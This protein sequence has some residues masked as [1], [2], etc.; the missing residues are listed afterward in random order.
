[1]TR[2]RQPDDYD[3]VLGALPSRA[4]RHGSA[5]TIAWALVAGLIALVV[6]TPLLLPQPLPTLR[7]ATF[8]AALPAASA[9]PHPLKE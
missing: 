5:V 1:M 2:D 3:A 6:V 8:A 7:W 9:A 4:T